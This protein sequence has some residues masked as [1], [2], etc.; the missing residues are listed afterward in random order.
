MKSATTITKTKG[1]M[2]RTK[3]KT[4]RTVDEDMSTQLPHWY[5]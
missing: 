5:C 1:A 2:M 4:I 3:P